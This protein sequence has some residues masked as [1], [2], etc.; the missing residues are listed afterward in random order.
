MAK[1]SVEHIAKFK[2]SPRYMADILRNMADVLTTVH[3]QSEG[4]CS[5]Y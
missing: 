3:P 4:D 2:Y 5:C 1:K